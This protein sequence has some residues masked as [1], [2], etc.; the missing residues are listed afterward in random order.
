MKH[1]NILFITKQFLISL[2][3]F[4]LLTKFSLMTRNY[5]LS[6]LYT[7]AGAV[8]IVWVMYGFLRRGLDGEKN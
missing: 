5:E 4:V 1:D 7:L 6:L 2:G 3:G 8:L